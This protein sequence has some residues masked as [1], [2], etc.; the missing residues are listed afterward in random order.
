VCW[1]FVRDS[2]VERVSPGMMQAAGQN[3]LRLDPPLEFLVQPLDRG[4]LHGA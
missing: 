3:R 2:A 4:T 1:G